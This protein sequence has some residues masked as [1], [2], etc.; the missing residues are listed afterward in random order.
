MYAKIKIEI[1]IVQERTHRFSHLIER[2]RLKNFLEVNSECK[3]KKV[4]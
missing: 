1:V 2:F 3:K 4:I